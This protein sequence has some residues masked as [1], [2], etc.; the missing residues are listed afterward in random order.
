MAGPRV[1]P[2]GELGCS[3]VVKGWP[4]ACSEV[5]AFAACWLQYRQPRETFMSTVAGS[6]NKSW[7]ACFQHPKVGW[8]GKEQN[9]A[10]R[11]YSTLKHSFSHLAQ[12]CL[13]NEA[14]CKHVSRK[15]LNRRI[16]CV[17]HNSRMAQSSGKQVQHAK[18]F[19]NRL[20]P[21]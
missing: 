16:V 3:L 1:F 20:Q 5:G 8:A 11:Q 6:M 12:C 18:Q 14:F 17:E 9:K 21:P 15:Q 19:Q 7:R 4:G 13:F 10:Q 2:K